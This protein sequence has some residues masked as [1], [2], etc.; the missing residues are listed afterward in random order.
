M[1]YESSALSV[2]NCCSLSDLIASYESYKNQI[3]ARENLK[4]NGCLCVNR[5]L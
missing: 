1:S 2:A 5:T 4:V 3:S